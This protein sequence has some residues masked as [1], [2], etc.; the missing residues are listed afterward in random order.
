MLCRK[1]LVPFL[2]F[3]LAGMV[4]ANTTFYTNQSTFNAAT[5]SLTFQAITDL[6]T[7]EFTP[8]G[9]VDPSTGVTFTDQSGGSSQLKVVN[10]STLGLTGGFT[11]GIQVPGTYTAYWF[12]IAS[13]SSGGSVNESSSSPFS[14]NNFTF[15]SPIFF[16]IVTDTAVTGLQVGGG[17]S[18]VVEI[19]N[20]NVAGSGASGPT[21]EGA[22]MLMIGSGLV[23]LRG[24]RARGSLAGRH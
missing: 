11:L 6:S 7:S 13:T 2:G 18:G 23:L 20:F 9:L 12:D 3:A 17:T 16:G 8:S 24:L 22:T 10:T 15:S 4:C 5:S 14:S 21:P 19:E 1:I